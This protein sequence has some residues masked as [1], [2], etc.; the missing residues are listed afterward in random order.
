MPQN[1]YKTIS[2]KDKIIKI[3]R[4]KKNSKGEAIKVDYDKESKGEEFRDEY[5][6]KYNLAILVKLYI[7]EIK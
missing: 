4:P 2:K 3:K 6:S 5:E 1:N 7:I